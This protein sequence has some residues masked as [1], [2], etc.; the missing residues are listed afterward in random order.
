MLNLIFVD[1]AC[2]SVVAAAL[3]DEE[4]AREREQ[5]ETGDVLRHSI[6]EGESLLL[7][8]L[9]EQLRSS[10]LLEKKGTGCVAPLVP[11]PH[12]HSSQNLSE[13]GQVER[14]E[15]SGTE[16]GEDLRLLAVGLR[17]SIELHR[18][19]SCDVPT[20][21]INSTSGSTEPFGPSLLLEVQ[22]ALSRLQ[23]SLQLGSIGGQG[24]VLDP[25]RRDALLQLVSRLQA[26]LQLPA[27]PDKENSKTDSP[28]IL[29]HSPKQKQRFEN[30]KMMR[31]NR[32]TVAV[33]REELDDARRVAEE[34]AAKDRL[35]SNSGNF[36]AVRT[37]HGLMQQSPA[38][39]LALPEGSVTPSSVVSPVMTAFRP[40][41]FGPRHSL[42]GL[43][44]NGNTSAK[45]FFLSQLQ[46][47]S[48]LRNSQSHA[49]NQRSSCGDMDVNSGDTA[50]TN[51]N[52]VHSSSEKSE[53]LNTTCIM[54]KSALSD[55]ISPEIISEFSAVVNIKN[56]PRGTVQK[57]SGFS[58]VNQTH[59]QPQSDKPVSMQPITA[60]HREYR[61]GKLGEEGVRPVQKS[62][63]LDNPNST[64]QNVISLAEQAIQK[65]V[66]HSSS[67][68]STGSSKASTPLRSD[69]GNSVPE[70]VVHKPLSKASS[71]DS[72]SSSKASTPQSSDSGTS[73]GERVTHKS[74]SQAPVPQRSDSTERLQHR[75]FSQGSVLSNTSGSK[76]STPRSD[77]GSSLPNRHIQKSVL[78]GSSSP[79]TTVAQSV[80]LDSINTSVTMPQGSAPE[81]RS[82]SHSVSLDSDSRDY[83]PSVLLFTPAQSVQIAVHKAAINKQLSLEE[84]K[85]QRMNAQ[86]CQ[87][88]YN[89]DSEDDDDDDDGSDVDTSSED[90]GSSETD[91]EAEENTSTVRQAA[92]SEKDQREFCSNYHSKNEND[93]HSQTDVNCA[94]IK[95]F[96]NYNP[97]Q[98]SAEPEILHA[99]IDDSGKH[100]AVKVPVT[101]NNVWNDSEQWNT[102]T[103]N[104]NS[105]RH[106]VQNSNHTIKNPTQHICTLQNN[107]ETETNSGN[108]C[109]NISSAQR[110]LQMATKDIKTFVSRSHG[111]S[112]RKV[113]M[114]RANTIDIPKPLNFYEIEE[115]TD[116][117]SE[118]EYEGD[119]D[120][121]SGIGS[122]S[123]HHQNTY[124]ALRGPIRLGSGNKAIGD[125]VAPPAFQ[126]KTESDRK[127]L[128]FLQQHS[129]GKGSMWRGEGGF[130]KTTSYNPS[131]R[132]GQHWSSRFTN[133]K[134]TFETSA[135]RDGGYPGRG[136]NLATSGP[137]TARTFWQS[138]DDSVTVVKSAAANGPKLTRQGS[139]FLKKLFE[140]KEQEQQS[141][142]PWTEKNAV[143]DDSVVVGSLTVAASTGSVLYKKQL[144]TPPQSPATV[145]AP[146]NINKFSHAPMS[147][148][149]PIE[150]KEKLDTVNQPV[151]GNVKE[152]GAQK[153]TAAPKTSKQRTG[154]NQH[155]KQELLSPVSPGLP[156]TRESTQLNHSMLNSAVEKFEN[157]SR[158]TSPQPAPFSRARS[159][160]Q[161]KIAV[162]GSLSVFVKQ[163]TPVLVPRSYVSS[164]HVPGSVQG[165]YQEKTSQVMSLSSPKQP[166]PIPTP[167]MLT[168][169]H[170][171]Q[172]YD[173]NQQNCHKEPEM[174][175]PSNQQKYGSGI[176]LMEQSGQ[177][178]TSGEIRQYCT[179]SYTTEI[180]Y[181]TEEFTEIPSASP[182]PQTYSGSVTSRSS[183]YPQSGTVFIPNASVRQPELD[184]LESTD[185]SL[186]SPEAFTA[187]SRIMTGPVSHQA[188]TV[189]HKTRHRY[190]DVDEDASGR[191]S[192]AKNLASVLIKFS[193]SSENN[194]N[195]Q[196][197]SKQPSSKSPTPAPRRKEED[198]IE[199]FKRNTSE[200]SATNSP[201]IDRL[202][203]DYRESQHHHNLLLK[204]SQK[205]RKSPTSSMNRHHSEPDIASMISDDQFLHYQ[206]ELH[207]KGA[208]HINS[209]RSPA[210][211]DQG[212]GTSKTVGN[213]RCSNGPA[214]GLGQFTHSG[215]VPGLAEE[216]DY[217]PSMSA[218]VRP[219]S[220]E[221]L[222]TTTSTEELQESGESI[223]TTRLQI[224][225]YSNSN[226]LH[227]LAKTFPNSPRSSSLHDVSHTDSPSNGMSISPNPSTSVSPSL[228]LRKSGSWH[229]LVAGQQGIRNKRPQSLALPD[230]TV[231][232]GNVRRI[233]PALPKTKS[234]HSLS[235]PKQFEA[236]LSPESVENKQRKVEAYLKTS[237]KPK[238]QEVKMKGQELRDNF[239]PPASD[240]LILDDNL[241]NVDEA[242][243]NVF[244]AT[245]SRNSETISKRN[246]AHKIKRPLR[247]PAT[248][249]LSPSHLSRSSS[250]QF[251]R[252]QQAWE[253]SSTV[254]T[255][256]AQH[257]SSK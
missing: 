117:S 53:S 173:N 31:Q 215:S 105:A 26:S 50:I 128:T 234:S 23:A 142:L 104:Q 124:L 19:Q 10:L 115:E 239:V 100:D 193:S 120:S 153:F 57:E 138:A 224:P 251:V 113:K 58:Q 107:T 74:V 162:P 164:A 136:R 148:F 202:R 216:S 189:T 88:T 158:E 18:Q 119:R 236:A 183:A 225:V 98:K 214:R 80:S 12:S 217:F 161:E 30:K 111:H 246:T 69:S 78:S 38:G 112:D 118:E 210:G 222:I 22:T 250:S 242:F 72:S 223:L 28:E 92:V 83:D 163:P 201:T 94:Q 67:T 180:N 44:S 184:S 207:M 247:Q 166:I 81:H 176:C 17:D 8:L 192:A 213:P 197:V 5:E 171:I 42:P 150:K 137:S 204:Q 235:F 205:E 4:A 51:L 151:G 226:K 63:S 32:H 203:Q 130:A 237:S 91:E 170:L 106:D 159:Q 37:A 245:V 253:E 13:G 15:D 70:K 174:C 146:V 97:K 6:E 39:D 248:E 71:L 249:E 35:T 121:R 231:S 186:P 169:P 212:N 7:P 20:Q 25:A 86:S 152:A 143:P 127:F 241:E 1:T 114:K 76:A 95:M 172:N 43:I 73:V 182:I 134:T 49:E 11:P 82:I 36:G 252:K 9:V 45:P 145:H 99:S 257:L 188:V 59:F 218:R 89:N 84:E 140:Q 243:E 196:S 54:N 209:F 40:V 244:N 60:I 141:K 33:T 256:L 64:I 103:V 133:I 85:R 208:K 101:N 254:R 96:N 194:R 116:Y 190:D 56:P 149:Q 219:A 206:Q 125:K 79:H 181:G 139:I 3:V 61:P 126:P 46:N 55:N 21:K 129:N 157:I 48:A 178:E 230:L 179:K 52:G 132:G 187:V 199:S 160:S 2:A 68:S 16:S 102:S 27:P 14:V 77:S 167:P 229:Q 155:T 233:P 165:R 185:T 123:D 147:A 62:G 177:D 135:G 109:I 144:F 238:S 87:K 41:H 240:M 200:Y 110:L 65:V 93:R 221:S 191:S 66:I 255:K 108:T 232:S 227:N 90:E 24:D 34:N 198:E 122:T 175:K 29:F 154:L 195:L 211:Q 47:S 220:T 75:S 131:A 228:T 156:W 168:A